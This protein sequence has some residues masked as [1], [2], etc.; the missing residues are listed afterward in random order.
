LNDETSS[1]FAKPRNIHWLFA[2]HH[3][4]QILKSFT[5]KGFEEWESLHIPEFGI[6]VQKR[7]CGSNIGRLNQLLKNGKKFLINPAAKGKQET[8]QVTNS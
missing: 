8:Y 7:K 2:D 1:V 5:G 4:C 6:K 3:L